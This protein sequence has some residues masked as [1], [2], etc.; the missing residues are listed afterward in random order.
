MAKRKSTSYK[1]AGVDIDAG[2]ELIRRIGPAARAT[3]RPELL[4]GLGGFAALAELPSGYRQ[5]VLVTGTD[6]V[7]TKLKLAAELGRYDT[8]GIDCVAMV[9]NDLVVQG[10]EPLFFLDY[11]ATGELDVSAAREVILAAGEHVRHARFGEGIVVSANRTANNSARHGPFN[12]AD[13]SDHGTNSGATK[14]PDCSS[15]P[16]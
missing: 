7:G 9:V 8:V 3:S 16:C 4:S 14:R 1:D 15:L 13:S 12:G 10:A 6:G 2:D 11:Y 5:P